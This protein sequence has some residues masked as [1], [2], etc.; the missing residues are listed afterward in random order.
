MMQSIW[1]TAFT[2]TKGNAGLRYIRIPCQDEEPPAGDNE[3]KQGDKQRRKAALV[4]VIALHLHMD[5]TM[6]LLKWAGI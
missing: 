5:D 1:V 6:A 3:S 2:A 4:F